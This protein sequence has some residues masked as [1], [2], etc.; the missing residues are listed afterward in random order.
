MG[1]VKQVR[2]QVPGCTSGED[3]GAFQ[4][5]EDCVSVAERTAEL[6]EHSYQ[7]HT[8]QV[9][10]SQAEAAKVAAEAA[11]VTA[12]AA[13]ITAEAE[14]VRAEKAVS[15]GRQD[16]NQSEK[17][18]VMSRPTIDEGVS[19]SDWSFFEAEWTRYVEATGLTVDEPG[20]I[21]HLWQACSDGLRR[22]LHN[23]GQER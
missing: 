22:A 18:A 10:Q 5:D 13:R 11:K 17:K 6:K 2:C 14:K 16:G 4:T 20:S 7:V 21:R 12:E 9:N 1:K 23:D 15:G 19:E 3:G 8:H